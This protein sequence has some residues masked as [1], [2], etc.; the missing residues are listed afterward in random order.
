MFNNKSA[1]N[2]FS[3]S[4]LSLSLT[5]STPSLAQGQQ[6]ADDI[7]IEIISVSG[8]FKRPKS[9]VDTPVSSTVLDGDFLRELKTDTLTDVANLTPN[10][11]IAQGGS[12]TN[13]KVAIRGISS[14]G[15]S[16]IEP[17][18]GVFIDDV[19]YPRSGSVIGNLYDVNT[20]EVLRGPQGTLF[21]RNTP[22]GAVTIQTNDPT[23]SQDGFVS[24]AFGNFGEQQLSGAYSDAISDTLALRIA[25]NLST[26]DGYGYNDLSQ[27]DVGDKETQAARLKLLFEPSDNWRTLFSFDISK[28]DSGGPIIELINETALPQFVGTLNAIYGA[29]P[30]TDDSFDRNINQAHNDSLDDEQYGGSV[31]SSYEFQTGHEFKVIA[32]HR[33]WDA[34]FTESLVRLTPSLIDRNNYFTSNNTSFELQFL[35]PEEQTLQ[36]VVGAY[37]YDESFDIDQDFALGEAYCSPTIFSVI[38]SQA[39]AQGAPEQVAFENASASATQCAGLEQAQA[40]SSE[41]NQDTRSYALFGQLTYPL[42]SSFEATLGGRYTRD[43]KDGSFVQMVNNPFAGL[44]RTSESSPDL[45]FDD[46]KFTW[47]ING[48]YSIAKNINVFASVSTGFK[49]GGFNSE[50]GSEALSEQNQRVFDSETTTN[51]EL[52]IKSDKFRGLIFGL[53]LFRIELDDFQARSFDGQTFIVRNAAELVQQ[54]LELDYTWQFNESLSL[55]GGLA[56][57]DSEFSDFPNA[58]GLPGSQDVQDL[59]GRPNLY[60]PDLQTTNAL[61]FKTSLPHTDDYQFHA[62]L[63]HQYTAEQD[64]GGAL[65]ANPQGIQDAYHLLGATLGLSSSVYAWR[66]EAYAGNL[67]DESYCLTIFEQPFGQVLG[68]IDAV[69]NTSAQRCVLGNPKTYGVRFSY[70][71]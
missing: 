39:L 58:P 48:Q 64:V 27:Q 70:D 66:I 41:F 67:T 40:I 26:R 62:T 34:E 9:I 68:A 22:A 63:S 42:T 50:G 12:E 7:P 47:F 3:L 24:L 37:L 28:L 51:Y 4:L 20:V 11:Q 35:S 54:G 32:A 15:N 52:G 71:F 13:S 5:T 14:V 6:N 2:T 61:R 45:A 19:F 65:N 1:V 44:F 25:A 18:V 30:L 23:F 29:T 38:L 43:E 55:M 49:S 31:E 59:K 10:F 21:G 36:Y 53:T 46:D 69:T 17:A 60:S 33:K 56:W 16:A 8:A 57:L